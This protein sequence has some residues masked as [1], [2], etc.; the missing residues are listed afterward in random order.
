MSA[1]PECT[2]N[3]GTQVYSTAIESGA[4]F[5]GMAVDN[6]GNLYLLYTGS[7]YGFLSPALIRAKYD[8]SGTLIY[9]TAV[10][11]GAQLDGMAVDNA[12]DLYILYGS[13][14][15]AKY[16]AAGTQVYAAVSGS[17]VQLNGMALDSSGNLSFAIT[18]PAVGLI[19]A[20]YNGNGGQ[21]YY[22][23]LISPTP[24]VTWPAPD[25]ISFGSA[26]GNAQLD[27]SSSIPGNICLFTASRNCLAGGSSAVA[28]GCFHAI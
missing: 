21:I 20:R 16:N 6:S 3:G 9:S 19:G 4:Q 18:S 7:A 25:D 13:L 10:A 5:S 14:I 12:G 17:G 24:P 15:R 22:E 11:S 2:W 23:T 27:A 1:N 26:L 28:V 8:V